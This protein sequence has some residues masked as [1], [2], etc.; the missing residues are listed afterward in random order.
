MPNANR[1][2]RVV[3]LVRYEKASS[4]R[5]PTESDQHTASP[6]MTSTSLQHA[7]QQPPDSR[8]RIA[9]MQE[10]PPRDEGTADIAASQ[11]QH[12]QS[13]QP[14]GFLGTT[15]DF[16]KNRRGQMRW[17]VAALTL[18]FGFIGLFMFRPT[19]IATKDGS[20]ALA[21]AVW[22]ARKSYREYCEAVSRLALSV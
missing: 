6:G 1:K 15:W 22:D 11:A 17:V 18:V 19:I 20:R 5:E 14:A 12:G 10:D 7:H 21:L 16:L 2:P 3:I 4:R 8:P 9:T 13:S